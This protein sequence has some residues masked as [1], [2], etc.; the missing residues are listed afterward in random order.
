M[1]NPFPKIGKVIKY[2]FK[3][4]SRIFLPIYAVILLL[5]LILGLSINQDQMNVILSTGSSSVS[6]DGLQG[7]FVSLLVLTSFALS[8][9]TLVMIE[10]RF[11]KELISDEAYVNLS[12]PVTA[13]EHIWG[14]FIMSFGWLIF[15]NI[16]E[17]V[18]YLLCFIRL[19]IFKGLKE[20][21][22]DQSILEEFAVYNLT[23]GKII[24]IAIV[25]TISVHI[26]FITFVYA[27]NSLKHIIKNM[28][29]I[30]EVFVIILLVTLYINTFKIIPD[31]DIQTFE[32]F[33]RIF[34]TI[35]GINL[36]FSVINFAFTQFVFT[37]SINLE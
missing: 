37:K 21:F 18:A 31:F 11:K 24:G 19:G 5:G 23:W 7:L 25:M 28:K 33:A 22:T 6:L 20:L 10:N 16:V 17:L 13:G 29:S 12:L 3:H 14:R 1:R 15:C 34:W 30:V 8:I 36:V 2:E 32:D 35:I 4:T 9:V 27:V 26:L